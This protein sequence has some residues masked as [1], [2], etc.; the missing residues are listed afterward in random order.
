MSPRCRAGRSCSSSS[1]S[2]SA[3]LL[4]LAPRRDVTGR[5]FDV[6]TLT[7]S[8]CLCDK[9]ADVF[10][11][12][13]NTS[14]SQVTWRLVA[15]LKLG[16]HYPSW[17]PELTAPVDGWPVSITRQHGPCW[18]A[19]VSTSRVDLTVNSGSG[20]RAL[21][22][23]ENRLCRRIT[24]YFQVSEIQYRITIISCHYNH[25]K[26]SSHIYSTACF[27]INTCAFCR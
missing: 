6:I 22:L 4:R 21:W 19:R 11:L 9:H 14:Q 5:C 16:F 24:A 26:F 15:T 10:I 2:S 1:S 12:Y 7:W 23:H 27:R 20:N 3:R 13:Y 18:R 25:F 8:L 17:R